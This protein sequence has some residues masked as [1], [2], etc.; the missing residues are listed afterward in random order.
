MSD[1][2]PIG[3]FD[4]G[5]GGLTVSRQIFRLMPGESTVYFGD[6][7]HVPYG[8][9]KPEELIGFA[10]SILTFLVS[11]GVKYV[12]F[13]CNTNSSISLPVVRERYA[14]PMIGLIEPGVREAVRV[15]TGGRIGVIATEATIKSGAYQR[16][17]KALNPELAV[18]GQAAPRLV[19]LVEAGRAGTREALEAVSEYVQ[20][21]KQAGMDTLILGCTH[22]PF[23][24]AEFREVL[25]PEVKLVDPAE[26]TIMA[27]REEMSRLGLLNNPGGG[28]VQHRY[29]VSGDPRVFQEAARHFLGED[30]PSVQQVKL[31]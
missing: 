12:I 30:I 9:R 4:S 26:A 3:L 27:A 5:V 11:C 24:E 13:A 10:E 22:Y 19:P 23:L 2:R 1:P 14:V 20:P 16:A 18:F 8:P 15:S 6:N 17:L 7:A 31:D 29:F 25:G 28:P 21:L